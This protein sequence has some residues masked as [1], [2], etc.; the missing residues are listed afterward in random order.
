MAKKNDSM[1]VEVLEVQRGELAFCVLGTTP[2][3][4]NRL[5]EKA[6]RELLLPKGR[7]STSDKASSLKHN[8]L[9]EFRSAA[10]WLANPADTLLGIPTTAFKGAMM[11]AALDMPGLSKAAIGRHVYVAAD[12]VGVYG[13]PKLHMTPVRSADMNRTPDIRTRV[14]VPEWAATVRVT[15]VKPI[16]REK[17]VAN[18]FAAAGIIAGVG[19]FRPEKGK[20]AYGQFELVGADDKRFKDIVKAG[21]RPA[22]VQAM[23][24]AEPYDDES[25]ELLGWFASE[26]SDRG[27]NIEHDGTAVRGESNASS[28]GKVAA[29][30]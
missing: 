7:K 18:L 4:L 16:L 27:W 6:K 22:Q 9:A 20:G 12:Y 24:N 10:H 15:F 29:G 21:G 28:N 8:P 5:S 1:N 23:D 14:I 26:A 3:I 25:R 30:R 17:I 11:T 19:D 13:I 2:L